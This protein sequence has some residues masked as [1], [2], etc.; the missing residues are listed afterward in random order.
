M[1]AVRRYCHSDANGKITINIPGGE[2]KN[3]EIIILPVSDDA[4]ER[5]TDESA[6]F[7]LMSIQQESG[8]AKTV[9]GSKEEDIWNELI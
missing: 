8:F 4:S 9:I 5:N 7:E 3:F 6:S 1:N 2:N